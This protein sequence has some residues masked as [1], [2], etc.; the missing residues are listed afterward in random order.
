LTFNKLESFIFNNLNH[1]SS[2]NLKS[3]II[4]KSYGKSLSL[5]FNKSH[6]KSWSFIFNKSYGKSLLL[7]FN[8]LE[9][10]IFNNLNHSSSI[11]LVENLYHWPSINWNHSSSI[12]F[13]ENLYHWPSIN[14]NYWSYNK[15]LLLTDLQ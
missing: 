3:F 11:N 10:L 7:T 6:G 8:K 5:T 1:S 13:M 9:S 4:N 15:F 2:I 12:N 14:W